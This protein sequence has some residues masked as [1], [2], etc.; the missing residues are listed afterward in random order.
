MIFTNVAISSLERR[1]G[2]DS[3][4]TGIV[5]GAYDLG[6]LLAVVPVTYYGGRPSSSKPKYIA[7]GM[8]LI[9]LGSTVFSLPHFVTNSYL[10]QLTSQNL[11]YGA[12][13]DSS[14]SSSIRDL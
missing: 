2:L 7:S 6:N 3:T 11:F 8:V 4:Q 10:E 1:F 13:A 9:S 14:S 12:E 5:V